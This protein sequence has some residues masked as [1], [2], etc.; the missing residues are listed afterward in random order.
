MDKKQVAWLLTVLV[1]AA[2]AHAG[3]RV[4]P[5]QQVSAT[6]FYQGFPLIAQSPLA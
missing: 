1:Q 2:T 4:E 5:N 3:P 6:E